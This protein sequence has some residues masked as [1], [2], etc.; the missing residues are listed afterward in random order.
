MCLL[1][2]TQLARSAGGTCEH[3]D[4]SRG[5]DPRC[6]NDQVA[7]AKGGMLNVDSEHIKPIWPVVLVPYSHCLTQLPLQMAI[8]LFVVAGPKSQLT[9]D[10]S[11]FDVSILVEEV[12][13]FD[14]HF[15]VGLLQGDLHNIW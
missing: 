10:G 2:G 1:P 12:G 6:C 9:A 14:N 4:E 3:H 11:H 5:S 7:T 15:A 8:Q 13:L